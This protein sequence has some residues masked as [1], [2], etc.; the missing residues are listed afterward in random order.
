[1][2]LYLYRTTVTYHSST[3]TDLT[4]MNFGF[5]TILMIGQLSDILEIMDI[6]LVRKL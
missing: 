3:V 4:L 5:I 2:T 6:I 1:M